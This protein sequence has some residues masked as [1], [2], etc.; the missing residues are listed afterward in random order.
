MAPRIAQLKEM[1]KE[2]SFFLDDVNVKGAIN[3]CKYLIVDPT[4]YLLTAL[5]GRVVD[6]DRNVSEP[7]VLLNDLDVNLSVNSSDAVLNRSF[8]AYGPE[9]EC[10]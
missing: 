2:L 10:S 1:P 7:P 8:P 5:R 6:Q 3:A 4:N 9:L